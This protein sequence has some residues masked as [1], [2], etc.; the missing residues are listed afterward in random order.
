MPEREDVHVGYAPLEE[1]RPEF[2]SDGYYWKAWHQC[3]ALIGQL[4]RVLGPEPP[5]CRLY[6]K[7][8]NHPKGKY[9][10]VNVSFPAGDEKGAQYARKCETEL[11]EHWD[12]EAK[13]ELKVTCEKS[14][15]KNGRPA[16][17][18]TTTPAPVA[19]APA[20]PSVQTPTAPPGANRST[21]TPPATTPAAVKAAQ[22]VPAQQNG[23]GTRKASARPQRKPH[24]KRKGVS[25]GR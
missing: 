7:E 8:N 20:S 14:I 25:H 18:A 6:I 13:R 5:R 15:P 22:D 12:E 4:R 24:P 21:V 1:E 2:G 16:L 17:T 23:N 11:P 10:S 9:L 19:T 3:R